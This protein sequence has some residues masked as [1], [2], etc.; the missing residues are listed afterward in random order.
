MG[1][2][3]ALRRAVVALA[4][5]GSMGGAAVGGTASAAQADTVRPN[6]A[7]SIDDKLEALAA[8]ARPGTLGI[9]VI[10][11]ETGH[12]WGVNQDDAFPMMSVFKVPVAAAVLDM[13]DRNELSLSE[14]IS[15]RRSDLRKGASEIARSF[16]GQ[17]MT[18]TVGQLLKA[19]VSYSDNTAVDALI[20]R[21]GGPAFNDIGIMTLPDGRSVIIAAFL[22]AAK[23]S[24]EERTEL[25]G[26][27]TRQ[28]A[29]HLR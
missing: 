20:K 27:L 21:I 8:R 5:L 26:E 15:I 28:V 23:M 7:S 29:S 25:F 1:G 10:D 24:R 18:F 2:I 9:S 17:R 3:S 13:V 6:A 14:S 12:Q 22:T 4:V 19:A 11:V 16:K